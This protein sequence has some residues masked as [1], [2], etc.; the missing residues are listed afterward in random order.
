MMDKNNHKKII[1]SK[2][3][4]AEPFGSLISFM[5]NN[6][7]PWGVKDCESRFMYANKA[8]LKYSQLPLNF[9]IEGRLDSECPAQWAEFAPDLQKQD[10][11]VE[12]DKKRVAMIQTCLF[13]QEH[14]L[15]E[16]F[17]LFDNEK[18]CIGT[19]FH[20]TKFNFIS[21]CDLFNK[22]PPPVLIMK[23]PTNDFTNKELEVIFFLLQ[24]LNAKEI[25]RKLNLSNR[26]IANKLQS[27]YGKANVNSQ[28][29]FKEYCKAEGFNRYIPEWLIKAGCTFI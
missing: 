6:D 4:D 8:T 15:C 13:G 3:L 14:T 5:E 16:K 19:I 10:R 21:I 22:T 20:V 17:P 27:I 9:D 29:A 12:T 25:G 28:S 1:G 18:K 11:A 26:T 7:E 24:S 2:E 23:P